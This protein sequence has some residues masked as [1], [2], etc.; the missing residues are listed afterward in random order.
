[1]ELFGDWQFWGVVVG[2]VAIL[3]TVI[4]FLAQRSKK[5]LAYYLLTETPLLSV[6][7]E[8][9]GKIKIRYGRKSIQNIHLVLLY[10]WNKGN[11]DI[12]TSDYEQPIVFSFPDSEIL[13]AEVVEVSPK[14]LQPTIMAELSKLTVD[15][16][17]LNKGDFMTIKLL[18]SDYAKQVDA[19]ARILGV[20]EIEK[21]ERR[22]SR[23]NYV[24]TLLEILIASVILQL[25]YL[26][27]SG[28]SFSS[29]TALLIF[30]GFLGL[31][32]IAI[33]VIWYFADRFSSPS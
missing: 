21:S 15:P 16:I 2:L 28:F 25:V 30:F 29:S 3:I 10:I 20:K 32:L 11:V 33:G 31:I 14:N 24:R 7:D 8:I 5:R 9:K 17:M 22:N 1:M 19:N 27:A 4:L 6:D 26:A 18:F 12:A 13:S 23:I